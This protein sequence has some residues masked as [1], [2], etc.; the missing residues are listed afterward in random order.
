MGSGLLDSAVPKWVR[1]RGHES[2]GAA[3]SVIG[4]TQEES[5]GE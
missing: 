3:S 4:A 1:W 2:V 5:G